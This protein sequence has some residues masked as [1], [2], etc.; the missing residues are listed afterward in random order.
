M[1]I[2]FPLESL[3]KFFPDLADLQNDPEVLEEK[4]T[5]FYTYGSIEPNV[6]VTDE[7]V[8]V[9]VDTDSIEAFESQYDR[10]VK[11]AEEGRYEK[12]RAVFEEL[13]E[14]HPGVSDLHRMYSQTF[15]EEGNIEDAL[16]HVIPALRWD[17]ENVHGL[18]LAGNI[19]LQGKG[20]AETAKK[21]YD[22]AA[23]IAPDNHL[24]LNN[25]GGMMLKT[26][27]PEEGKRYLKKALEANEQYP[28]THYGLALA[29]KNEGSLL[30][31]FEQAIEGLRNASP[32]NQM[33][34]RLEDLADE[35]AETY[36]EQRDLS[37]LIEGYVEELE[38]RSGKDIR[39][40]SQSGT[41]NPASLKVAENYDRD[42]HQ[43]VYNPSKEHRAH[44]VMHELVHLDFILEARAD[45]WNELFVTGDKHR[46][47]FI[48]DNRQSFDKMKDLGLE[49]RQLEGMID[50]LFSGLNDQ[51]YN[52]PVDLFIEKK[53]YEDYPE[54][55]PVQYASLKNLLG[56]YIEGAT[57]EMKDIAPKRVW[58]ANVALNLTHAYL[59]RDLYGLDYEM[60]FRAP[61]RLRNRAKRFY[62]DY[63]EIE[64]AGRLPGEEYE[65][66]EDWAASLNV[67][68]YH[69]LIDESK[70]RDVG[71]PDDEPQKESREEAE[72]ILEEIEEDPYDLEEKAKAEGDGPQISFEDNP[73]GSMAVTM[74]LV[75]A[76]KFYN[77]K[78]ED[79]IQSVAFEIAM[80][81][82]Q[83]IDPSNI[84]KRYSLS[85]VPNRE[86]SP[87]QLLAYMF[88]GFKKL[89]ESVDTQLDFEDEYEQAEAMAELDD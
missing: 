49:G 76:I 79:E 86:F 72:R 74:H 60:E 52:A 82:R 65:L 58:A 27:R 89:D 56:T 46:Q 11:L 36:E 57:N 34:G 43:V 48:D 32:N 29:Y 18:T 37:D 24:V 71:E 77:G 26:G 78:S 80:L 51:V 81:G 45:D 69:I 6:E 84:D 40:V 39:L 22:R 7:T 13:L 59:F 35:I 33:H 83:G 47:A 9:D 61:R 21:Y 20:D 41:D 44:L 28:N 14:E 54:L 23:E 73:A 66:I 75:D 12:A 42:E 31:G 5:E 17:P 38:G 62:G 87:L 67:G 88:A 55:R 4:L 68:E 2:A 25:L 70:H 30:K 50:R 85:S 8:R 3:P 10:G 1:H 19:F 53:L 63:E 15:F 16:D 64:E